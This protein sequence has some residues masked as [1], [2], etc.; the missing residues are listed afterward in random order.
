MKQKSKVKTSDTAVLVIDMLNDFVLDNAPLFVPGAKQ[1]IPNIRAIL[2]DARSN[3]VPVVYLVDTHKHDDPEFRVWPA[4]AVKGTPGDEIVSEL[5]PQKNDI[6][7]RKTT[8]SG[9]YKTRLLKTL[10]KLR[11]K[12]LIITGVATEICVQYTSAD[13]YMNGFI[14]DVPDNSTSALTTENKVF[15]LNMIKNVLKPRQV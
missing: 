2:D 3:A 12:R 1:I 13:A 5:A 4:H 14:V 9:F 8:Y 6:I 15:A 10:K 11:V 7:I